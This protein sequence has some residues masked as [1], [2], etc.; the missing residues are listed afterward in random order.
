MMVHGCPNK[1][2]YLSNS[3]FLKKKDESTL[4]RREDVKLHPSGIAQVKIRIL[5]RFFAILVN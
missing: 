1:V 5:A 2:L 3:H 4:C